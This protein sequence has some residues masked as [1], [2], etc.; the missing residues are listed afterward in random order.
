MILDI[1]ILLNNVY[2]SDIKKMGRRTQN[3]FVIPS[4]Q[5]YKRLRQRIMS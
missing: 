1:I 2:H 5:H 3:E 4:P